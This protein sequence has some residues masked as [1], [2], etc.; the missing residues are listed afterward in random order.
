L[1]AN[2]PFLRLARLGAFSDFLATFSPPE[3]G[4]GTFLDLGSLGPL[5]LSTGLLPAASAVSPE[6]SL[7]LLELE[8]DFSPT[9]DLLLEYSLAQEPLSFLTRQLQDPGASALLQS[10]HLPLEGISTLTGSG[11]GSSFRRAASLVA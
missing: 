9:S 1:V 11:A 3:P 4:A 8:L 7:S 6:T 2:I 10:G 5:K